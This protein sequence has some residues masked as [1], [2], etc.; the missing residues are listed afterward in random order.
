M[1]TFREPGL[2]WRYLHNVVVLSW[3]KVCFST[4]QF[5]EQFVCIRVLCLSCV[6]RFPACLEAL[7]ASLDQ[8]LVCEEQVLR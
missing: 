1:S 4:L 8:A 7:I 3:K 2:T 6:I 5:K